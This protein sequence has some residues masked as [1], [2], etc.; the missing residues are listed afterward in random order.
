MRRLRP[1]TRAII[2]YPLVCLV[3][4]GG[5]VAWVW[6]DCSDVERVV[7]CRGDIR[8]EWPWFLG[9]IL[10]S[11]LA[12]LFLV[13]LV[14]GVFAWGRKRPAAA[15]G[16]SAPAPSELDEAPAPD[17][18]MPAPPPAVPAP[19]EEGSSEDERPSG[20]PLAP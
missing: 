6:V 15:T 7:A 3:A 13:W 20:R 18:A 4:T 10:V 12:V 5:F 2:W 19:P 16:F 1:I 14:S 9:A 11:G 8:S 17:P